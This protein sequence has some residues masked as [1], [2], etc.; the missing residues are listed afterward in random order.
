MHVYITNIYI[1]IYIY[2][3]IH[4]HTHI[5]IRLTPYYILYTAIHNICPSYINTECVQGHLDHTENNISI[6][7]AQPAHTSVTCAFISLPNANFWTYSIR[8]ITY[9]CIIYIYIITK[10][11]VGPGFLYMMQ[12]VY[13]CG[14]FQSPWR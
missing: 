11:Y 4:I 2:L 5:W 12:H 8:L 13:I 3:Y 7:D 14:A 1:Y 9:I 10:S 6:T